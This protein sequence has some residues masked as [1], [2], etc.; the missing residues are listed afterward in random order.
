M[1]EAWC[2][3]P[4]IEQGLT[5]SQTEMLACASN[6]VPADRRSKPQLN[7]LQKCPR[8]DSM[9]TKFCYYNNYSLTQPRYFCKNCK[10]YWTAGGALRNVPVGGGL[11]K[12]KRSKHKEVAAAARPA[13]SSPAIADSPLS[14]DKS[15]NRNNYSPQTSLVLQ[16]DEASFR[17]PSCPI[18][19]TQF[20]FDPSR[21][22]TGEKRSIYEA[23]GWELTPHLSYGELRDV[24]VQVPFFAGYSYSL[25]AAVEES[26]L[27]QYEDGFGGYNLS[28]HAR[29][30]SSQAQSSTTSTSVPFEELAAPCSTNNVH[31]DPGVEPGCGNHAVSEPLSLLPHGTR[32]PE[33]QQLRHIHEEEEEEE[34]AA[35]G[36]LGRLSS[37]ELHLQ[38]GKSINS[39]GGTQECPASDEVSTGA[40]I[41]PYDWQLISEGLFGGPA[42]DYFYTP[43]AGWPD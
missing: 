43:G 13:P 28:G 37:G 31:H 20:R 19:G 33:V 30:P 42:S 16:E 11:R 15:P 8:C 12:N 14:S 4:M 35:G 5:S 41:N 27:P 1:V 10:R 21:K 7:Q 24:Q 6:P 40:V 26:G 32:A 29:F 34:E 36:I 23:A 39:T 22:R 2:I 9:D 25:Q 3:V 17:F 18:E 38:T